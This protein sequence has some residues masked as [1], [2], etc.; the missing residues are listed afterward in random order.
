MLF[1]RSVKK[2]LELRKKPRY[3]SSLLKTIKVYPDDLSIYYK[4]ILENFNKQE[5]DNK[6]NVILTIT[7]G[8]V[9]ATFDQEDVIQNLNG[10][11]IRSIGIKSNKKN[12]LEGKRFL[13]NTPYIIMVEIDRAIPI[14]EKEFDQIR[15][16]IILNLKESNKY[17]IVLRGSCNRCSKESIAFRISDVPANPENILK[18][19]A[20]YFFWT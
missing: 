18:F 10:E 16:D 4:Q 9:D 5:K 14:V 12:I 7:N 20:K 3:K 11:K 1:V 15:F 2:E 13:K 17:W 8:A 6:D 19:M